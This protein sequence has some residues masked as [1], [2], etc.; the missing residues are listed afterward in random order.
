MKAHFLAALLLGTKAA[1]SSLANNNLRG[2]KQR[3]ESTIDPPH[4]WDRDYDWS[5][6]FETPEPSSQMWGC[7][8]SGWCVDPPWLFETPSEDDDWYWYYR[9]FEPPFEDSSL[10]SSSGDNN[11]CEECSS[12]KAFTTMTGVRMHAEISPGQCEDACVVAATKGRWE[13]AGWKCGPCPD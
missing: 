4:Q 12:S 7:D 13:A 8:D 10:E 11:K 6:P 9:S 1:A 2:K 3:D 5:L